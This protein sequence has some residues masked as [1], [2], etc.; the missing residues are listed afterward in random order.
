V[1]PLVEFDDIC[2]EMVI[3][4]SS[5]MGR[6]GF[7][8]SAPEYP[9]EPQMYFLKSCGLSGFLQRSGRFHHHK[10]MT[11]GSEDVLWLALN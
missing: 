8:G 3:L 10:L 11:S 7:L 6:K 4:V 9:M 2:L 1:I 5:I